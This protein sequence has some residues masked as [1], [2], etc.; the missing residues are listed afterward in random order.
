MQLLADFS[1]IG[2][3]VSSEIEWLWVAKYWVDPNNEH[4]YDG[5]QLLNLRAAWTVTPKLTV[6][7]VATNLLDEGYAERADFG[8]G[9][10]RYFVGEPRSAVIG[11]TLSL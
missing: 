8:F 9:N 7:V 10:Y 2:L 3:P 1:T 11:L 4:Q 6:T 5:H